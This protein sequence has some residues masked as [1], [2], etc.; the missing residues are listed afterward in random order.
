MSRST[1]DWSSAVL[2]GGGEGDVADGEAEF[3]SSS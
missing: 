1:W 2:E 3:R